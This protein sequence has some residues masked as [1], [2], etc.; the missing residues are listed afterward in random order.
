ME[1]EQA[2]PST[3]HMTTPSFSSRVASDKQAVLSTDQQA[4]LPHNQSAVPPSDQSVTPPLVQVATPPTRPPIKN[5]KSPL[6]SSFEPSKKKRRKDEQSKKNHSQELGRTSQ[7]SATIPEASSHVNQPPSNECVS[8][9]NVKDREEKK[10]TKD[11]SEPI[12]PL[13]SP[14]VLGSDTKDGQEDVNLDD[15]QNFVMPII[16]GMEDS[17]QE[18]ALNTSFAIT[19]ELCTS[20][21]LYKTLLLLLPS[22]SDSQEHQFTASNMGTG[23]RTNIA[24]EIGT[25]T[26]IAMETGTRTNIA[27][28]TG[29]STNIRQSLD[30]R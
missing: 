25:R 5:T 4:N 8:V 11:V 29:M 24:M 23:M 3:D 9:E 15:S 1:S 2:T 17:E 13:I 21:S 7:H 30:T 27:M 10:N 14:F 19:S 6:L 16:T 18:S 26:N 20:Q 28:E 12:R 22:D